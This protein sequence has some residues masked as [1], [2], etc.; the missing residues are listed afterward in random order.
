V[1]HLVEHILALVKLTVHGANEQLIGAKCRPVHRVAVAVLQH[2]QAA[3]VVR[4][5]VDLDLP[6]VR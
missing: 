6:G 2:N 5:A 3:A 4:F 1:S